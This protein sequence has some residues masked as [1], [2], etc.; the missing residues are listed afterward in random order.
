MIT[1]RLRDL[2]WRIRVQRLRVSKRRSYPATDW[3]E[4]PVVIGNAMAKS[5]SHVIAQFLEGLSVVSP[6]VFTDRHPIRTI[7]PSG[8]P[9]STDSTLRQMRRLRPGDIGWGYL[10]SSAPFVS[11]LRRPR[12]LGIF[13]SR[14]PRDRIISQIMYALKIH[15]GHRMRAS[16][17][18]LDS[19]QE[20]IAVSIGGVPGK[21]KSVREIYDSY[22]GWTEVGNVLCV[23]FEDFVHDRQA[24]LKRMLEYLKSRGVPIEQPLSEVLEALERSLDSGRSPTFRS[25]KSGEWRDHF[26]AANVEQFKAVAGDLLSRLGYEDS[27]A[28]GVHRA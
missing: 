24:T 4:L 15:E 18:E 23:R 21:L 7:S 22:L 13:A 5:G 8:E 12:Y 26:S 11:E 27:E 1:D 19:M 28:W 6:M 17:L 2:K 25:G 16:Y 3:Q 10:P 14:D 20:R 9:Q